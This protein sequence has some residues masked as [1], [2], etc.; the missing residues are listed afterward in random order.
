MSQKITVT[1]PNASATAFPLCL[2]RSSALLP[3][4]SNEQRSRN[5]VI[6]HNLALRPNLVNELRFGINRF[7]SVEHFPVSGA[8]AVSALGLQV[9]I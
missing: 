7:S 5:L 6:S 1:S 2:A 4:S 9:S 3:R 8:E